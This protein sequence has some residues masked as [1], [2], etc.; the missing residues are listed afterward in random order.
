MSTLSPSGLTSSVLRYVPVHFHDAKG[1]SNA[2]LY[3]AQ[4]HDQQGWLPPDP[5]GNPNGA[6]KLH[7]VGVP[8]LFFRVLPLADIDICE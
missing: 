5:V 4:P 2:S 3:T 7:N 8:L 1:R 6:D